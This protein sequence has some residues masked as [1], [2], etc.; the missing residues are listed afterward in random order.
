MKIESLDSGVVSQ[1]RNSGDWE[2]S[3]GGWSGMID[4][5]QNS[6]AF[7]ATNLF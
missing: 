2:A 6:Y 4:P 7:M 5:D 3:A 1:R